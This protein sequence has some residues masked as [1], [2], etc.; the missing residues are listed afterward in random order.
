VTLIEVSDAA[1]EKASTGSGQSKLVAK[2]KMAGGCGGCTRIDPR[3]TALEDVAPADVIEA[4]T[5]NYDVKLIS[6]GSMHWCVP[7]DHRIQHVLDFVTSSQRRYRIRPLH[8]DALLQPGAVMALVE[9]VRGLQ[10]TDATH[11]TAE[12]LAFQS[13]NRRSPSKRAD[14][15][16]TAF[17]C[18]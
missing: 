14:S 11:D 1:V 18:R 8:R 16:S 9:I 10:T 15:S 13:A 7:N 12:A 2:G 6:K 3:T 4:V 17:R 5:E